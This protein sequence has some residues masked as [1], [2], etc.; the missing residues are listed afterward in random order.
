MTSSV[1][2]G[3]SCKPLPLEMCCNSRYYSTNQL[4]HDSSAEAIQSDMESKVS[5][6]IRT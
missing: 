1:D 5:L 4:D 6:T 3:N 2:N